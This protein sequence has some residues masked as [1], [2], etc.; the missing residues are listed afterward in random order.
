MSAAGRRT[1]RAPDLTE[2]V[3]VVT[4]GGRGIGATLSR[5]YAAAGAAVVASGRTVRALAETV[6]AIRADGGRAEAVAAD[7]SDPSDVQR[8]CDQAV[9]AFG[10]LDILVNNAG[11]AG[12]TKEL[13]NV[14]LEEWTEVLAVN[15]TGVFLCCQAAIPVMRERGGG[16][17]VNV[18]SASGKRPLAMRTPYTASKMGLVGLTRTLADEVAK[19]EI[20]VNCISPW[21]VQNERVEQVISRMAA[22]RGVG[23]DVVRT[24]LVSLSPFNRGVNEDDVA[25]VALFLSSSAADNMTGQDINVTAGAVKY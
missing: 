6:E 18:G 13:V 1:A 19:D 3:A 12:P 22:A 9:E 16:K 5:R 25:N 11:I 14:T 17:I 23:R 8:I 24:E 2:Q 10:G 21:M 4:G 15:L 7:V 20:T